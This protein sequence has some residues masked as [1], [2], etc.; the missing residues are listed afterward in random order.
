M[1][2]ESLFL[3]L[4]KCEFEMDHMEYLGLILDK[5]TIQPDPT[6]I[7]GLCKWPRT[8]AQNLEISQESL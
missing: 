6:K 8:M 5:D 4:S 3:K 1:K 7:A 2:N